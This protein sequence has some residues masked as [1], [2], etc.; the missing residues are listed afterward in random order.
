MNPALIGQIANWISIAIGAAPKVE[1]AVRDAI[2]FIDGLFGAGVIDKATQDKLMA[3][4]DASLLS[5]IK[6]TPPPAWTVEPDP[7]VGTPPA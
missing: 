3:H 7:T 1:Q 2:V 5:F 4:I 6:N